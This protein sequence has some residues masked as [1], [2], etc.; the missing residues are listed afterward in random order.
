M[1]FTNFDSVDV[2]L[3]MA[4]DGVTLLFDRLIPDGD[5]DSDTVYDAIR[6]ASIRRRTSHCRPA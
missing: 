1:L 4:L 3:N 6:R 5:C 2:L